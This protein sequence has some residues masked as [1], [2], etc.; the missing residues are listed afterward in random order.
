MSRDG[1]AAPRSGPAGFG[2][3]Q[4]VRRVEDLRFLT[5]TGCYV[6]DIALPGQVH[7]QVL[8]SPVA[9]AGIVRLDADRAR[10]LPGVLAVLTA[11]DLAAENVGTLPCAVSLDNRDGSPAPWPDYPVLARDRVRFC[12]EPVAFVVAGTRAAALDAAEAVEI[13]YDVVAAVTD[14][15]TGDDVG[16][17]LVHGTHA[18]N[19]A[20]DWQFGDPDATGKAFATAATV[21]A[22]DL[23]N[24]RLAACPL[25]PRGAVA[26]WDG[27]AGA[28]TLY[29][30][31]QGGWEIKR[32]LAERF[33]HVEPAHVRVVTPDVGGGFGMKSVIYAE[34][35]LC[36]LAAR[37]LGRPV[38]WTASRSESFV[39]DTHG[40]DHVTRAELALDADGRITALRVVTRANMG[41]YP[42]EFAP[43]IP[44]EGA[45]KVLTGVY[46]VP[47]VSYR[48]IGIFTN[49]TP[50]DAYRGAGRP[51]SNYMIERLVDK[52][53]RTLGQDPAGF[54]LANMIPA[55]A[56]PY[57]TATG[58]LYDTGDF[59]GMLGLAL[60][61]AGRTGFDARR[62]RS[63]RAGLRRGLGM[64]SY[65]ESTMGD[66]IEFADIRF[67]AD[68][69]VS[70]DVGTQSNGQGHE[71]A[72]A[73]VLAARLGVDFGKIS[74]V[75]GDTDRIAWGGGTG[76][77]RSLTIQAEAINVAGDRVIEK[78]RALA[79]AEFEVAVDDVVFAE[80]EL[81]VAGTDIGTSLVALA[82]RHV[83][84]LDT[85][86]SA[87]LAAWTFP[88][89]CHVAEVE[90][91]PE[92][93]RAR[94]VAYVIVDDFGRVVNPLLL[95]GQVI[96]GVV[97]GIGQAL[98]EH[99]RF[100]EAGQPVT[101]SFMD[102]ALPR[103]DDLPDFDFRF[104]EIPSLNNA[105][106]IKG[107]GEAGAIAAPPAVINAL[108]DAISP[109]EGRQL[110][111][112]DMPAGAE[113]LWAA[114]AR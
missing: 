83:G 47:A 42:S 86:A 108:V 84:E 21:I 17:P 39:A 36:A 109:G 78:A 61:R 13:D 3:G 105:M 103:A 1:P 65:V 9:S 15:R 102:Y 71:T 11:A 93:G 80:G 101:G 35:A 62:R 7:A 49:T 100:D 104:V 77:S 4:P 57:A 52:A 90:V 27:P 29:A 106:G 76:G 41:A 45:L 51:E 74:V 69:A 88:N 16:Q 55:S 99:A 97:Q 8:R 82:A 107:C 5:G 31:T 43:F 66:A 19:V 114:L 72:Y 32:H 95:E 30:N 89:G 87:E 12:G 56:M 22:L 91:D 73:Q 14:L 44:T 60:D 28:L 26:V 48:V 96:G 2:I 58:E 110:A 33:L 20:F 111:E 37:R 67:A 70:V 34:H 92:T 79:A 38:K 40:R 68:G 18:R 75:Q 10:A 81:L 112:I 59:P 63:A 98:L 85:R 46:R 64:A 23:V 24:N 6:D 53:A 94:I 54:R 50:V 25:E 113:R